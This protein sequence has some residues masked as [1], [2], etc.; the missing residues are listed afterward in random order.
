MSALT[1][2]ALNVTAC[3]TS[4]ES[5][6]DESASLDASS[7]VSTDEQSSRGEQ[8]FLYGAGA[9]FPAPLYDIWI[10]EYRKINPD[11]EI[12]YQAVG[13][14]AGIEEFLAQGVD[15]GATEAPLTEENKASF[16][17]ERGRP[18]QIPIVGGAVVFGYNLP[19]VENLRLS[20]QAYCGVVS[21]DITNW[22]DPAI[23]AD[24]PD[25][26][27]P[28]LPVKF[29]HRADSS[30]TTF[31]FTQHLASACPGWTADA[32]TVIDWPVGTGAPGNGGITANIKQSEGTIGYI[33]FAHAE[34]NFV[35]V[36][37]LENKAGNFIEPLP[38][39]AAKAA[40]N[41]D[42][43]DDFAV[44]IPD[45][46]A[47]DAYPIIGLT[48]MLLYGAYP[49]QREADALTS[50]IQWALTDGSTYADSMGYAPLSDDLVTEVTL[51]LNEIQVSATP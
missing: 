44:L 24:N 48:F 42:I 25:A 5:T 33:T 45:P 31:V 35:Q 50:F 17:A 1:I 47:E 32:D 15:F 34:Q 6:P 43:P 19:E 29:V 39:S 49:D 28:D 27:L 23:A 22:S 4:T 46:D 9:T 18:I 37:E 20:R 10:S 11:V 30:G 2:C 14:G 38:E 51:T 26:T 12:Q 36:A 40:E 8:I 13:S 7:D 3:S 41:T 16:P 21:G